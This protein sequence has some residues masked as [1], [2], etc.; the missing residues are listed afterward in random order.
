[1]KLK[2]INLI[3][4]MDI[5]EIQSL[6][7]EPADEYQNLIW[8]AR[9]IRPKEYRLECPEE[10]YDWMKMTAAVMEELREIFD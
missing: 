8:K 1:L 9:P 10:Y 2:F 7:G 5:Q 4:I 3:G 6:S